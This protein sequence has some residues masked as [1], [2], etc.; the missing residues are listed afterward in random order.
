V[1]LLIY[2]HVSAGGFREEGISPSVLCEGFGML[3]TAV[4]DAKSA[5]HTVTAILDEQLAGFNPPLKAETKIAVHSIA[6]AENALL[7]SAENCDA[8]YVIAPETHDKLQ[9][10]VQKIQQNNVP[11]L[12]ST[13][14][15]IAQAS[16]KLLLQQ[17]A[18]AIGL[19]TPKTLTFSIEDNPDNVVEAI[20]EKIGFPTV[21]KPPRSVGC[22]A[23][24]IV[25]DEEQA[26]TAITKLSRYAN[27]SFI[28]Q[29]LIQ[30]TAASVTLISNGIEA[31]PITLNRQNISLKS[32]N[33]DSAYNGGTTPLDDTSKTAAYSA[34]KKLVESI[35]GLQGYVGVDL[36]LAKNEPVVIEVNPRLTTSYI[37]IR[38][39]TNLNLIEATI[40]AVPMHELPEKQETTGYAHFEKAKTRNPTNATLQQTFNMPEIVSP[41]FPLANNTFTYAL[42]CAQG[43][44]QHQAKQ[45][46]KKAKA[47][48]EKTLQEGGKL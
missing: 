13:P 11:S 6:D 1:K 16:N 43:A 5:G 39:T 24:I 26:R 41:P 29:Q 36:V 12:N 34:A 32:P 17:Q 18:S 38:K 28:A 27:S 7:E 33:Q 10:L 9:Q 21:L 44:T 20:A 14:N 4:E 23:L 25:N 8:V 42:I 15:A 31:Q 37:G 40:N 22:E 47:H 19:T 3:R 2:E 30:G 46:F 48:L 45:N 35:K